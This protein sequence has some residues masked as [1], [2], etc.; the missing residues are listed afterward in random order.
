MDLP[1]VN[2][3]DIGANLTSEMYEGK[4]FGKKVPSHEADLDVVLQRASDVGVQKVIVTAG[5]R[6]D[7]IDALELVNKY[8]TL[9]TTIGVHP[10]RC[11]EMDS[12][13]DEY[14]EDLLK[15]YREH[16]TP[17]RRKIVAVGELGLDYDRLH[18]CKKEVQ[19]RNFQLQF[20]L[21]E[22]TGLPLFLHMRNCG[23]DFLRIVKAHRHTF[24]EGVV[25]SFTGTAEEVLGILDLGLYIGINGC[26]L[27][28]EENLKIVDT[29]PLDKMMIETDAPYCDIRSTHASNKH[30]KT[31]WPSKKKEKYDK[32]SFVKGRNEPCAILQVLEVICERRGIP[33]EEA[34]KVLYKNTMSVFFP[35]ELSSEEKE[36]SEGSGE[37]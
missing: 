3:I 25:H 32:Q 6:Q 13:P 20:R 29:I 21:A 17:D 19:L 8:P 26:S 18:F 33:V 1:K 31:K 34:A 24:R 7:T 9:T 5:T 4:Y 30:V 15:F 22:A 16:N 11:N 2:M 23:S 28:T 10:T 37:K 35:E 14:L 36:K 12:N 27:K